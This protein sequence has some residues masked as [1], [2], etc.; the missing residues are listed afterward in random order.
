MTNNSTISRSYCITV[1]YQLFHPK[2]TSPNPYS[3]SLHCI[4][5]IKS[6]LKKILVCGDFA[7]FVLISI[8]HWDEWHFSSARL[9]D[10]QQIVA[11]RPH[12]F[13][14]ILSASAFFGWHVL[15]GLQH[16]I[17]LHIFNLR[18]EFW[19]SIFVHPI[20]SYQQCQAFIFHRNATWRYYI[21]RHHVAVREDHL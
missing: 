11:L 5:W 20:H 13:I 1:R 15:V 4:K 14:S 3:T 2:L 10:L 18:F 21:S 17:I 8:V 7:D 19:S 6:K 16:N 12:L 9:R